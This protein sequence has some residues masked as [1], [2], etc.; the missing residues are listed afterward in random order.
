M[1]EN[2]CPSCRAANDSGAVFCGSCGARMAPTAPQYQAPGYQ[3]QPPVQPEYGAQPIPGIPMGMVPA[4]FGIRLGAALI[5]IVVLGVVQYVL[6]A[7]G[8]GA[9]SWIIGLAYYITFWALKGATPGKMALGLQIVA[10]DGRPMDWGKAGLRYVGYIVSAL[11]LLI[12]FLMIAFDDQSRGLH[13]RI[14]K[15]YVVK[16]A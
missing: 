11:I 16:R 14:A 1:S 3:Q 4:G 5:D 13:D 8:A 10:A 15:T 12:G 2:S 9:L 7:V 6:T